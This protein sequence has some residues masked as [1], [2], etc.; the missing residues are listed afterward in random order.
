[1][2]VFFGNDFKVGGGG[3]GGGD[4]DLV[5]F[6]QNITGNNPKLNI[7]TKKRT[8]NNK[9]SPSIQTFLT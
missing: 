8:N 9:K 5:D 6:N 7:A 1:M 4:G 2:T 3:G